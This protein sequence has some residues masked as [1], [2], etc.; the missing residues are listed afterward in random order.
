MVRIASEDPKQARKDAALRGLLDN[1]ERAVL[2]HFECSGIPDSWDDEE[3]QDIDEAKLEAANRLL[4]LRTRLFRLASAGEVEGIVLTPDAMHAMCAEAR[5]DEINRAADFLLEQA[6]RCFDR[7]SSH[8]HHEAQVLVR[9][10]ALLRDMSPFPYKPRPT[11][12]SFDT[13]IP[14]D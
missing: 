12:V 7:G 2:D 9:Y 3:Q 13:S 14:K 6:A 5:R 8:D 1:Y 10:S 11:E 4:R